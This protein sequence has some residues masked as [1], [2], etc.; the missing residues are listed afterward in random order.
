MM[1]EMAPH[2]TYSDSRQGIM[3]QEMTRIRLYRLSGGGNKVY[4]RYTHPLEQV[5]AKTMRINLYD[6]LCR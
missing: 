1:G 3:S 4:K 2:L 6:I 5:L